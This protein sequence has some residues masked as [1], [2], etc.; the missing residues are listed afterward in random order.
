MMQ[1]RQ[2]VPWGRH[3]RA[4]RRRLRSSSTETATAPDSGGAEFDQLWRRCR[5]NAT[6]CEAE[7]GVEGGVVSRWASDDFSAGLLTRL[8]WSLHGDQPTPIKVSSAKSADP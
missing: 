6:T 7:T 4:G 2:R 5:R 1:L 8:L 3:E